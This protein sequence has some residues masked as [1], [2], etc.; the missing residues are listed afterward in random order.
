MT[1]VRGTILITVSKDGQI[2]ISEIKYYVDDTSEN[3]SVDTGISK[4]DDALQKSSATNLKQKLI[5]RIP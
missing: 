2:V 1:L 3:N 4:T 5:P